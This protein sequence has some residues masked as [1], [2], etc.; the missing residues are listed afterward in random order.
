MKEEKINEIGKELG[1]KYSD[2]N[3]KFLSK[4]NHLP[5]YLLSQITGLI[6]SVGLSD[7]L[8]HSKS[9]DAYPFFNYVLI[10][11]PGG[12]FLSI[13]QTVNA[14][15]S[16]SKPK[17]FG[18]SRKARMSIFIPNILISFWA[19]LFLFMLVQRPNMSGVMYGVYSHKGKED[20]NKS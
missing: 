13:I 15:F 3:K 18:L 5:F 20:T 17:R 10:G 2:I 16:L 6:G 19:V 11:I 8:G 14:Y 12:L 7:Y 4:V 1:V 9:H